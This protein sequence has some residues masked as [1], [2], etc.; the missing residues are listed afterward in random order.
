MIMVFN[1]TL[2]VLQVYRGGQ[3]YWWMKPDFPEK[4]KLTNGN[5]KLSR[6]S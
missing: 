1:T 3:F 2:T 4:G 6:L 5:V